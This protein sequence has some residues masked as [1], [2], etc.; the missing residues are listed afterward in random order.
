MRAGAYIYGNL[1]TAYI[2]SREVSCVIEF[3]CIQLCMDLN[4][5]LNPL[6]PLDSFRSKHQKEEMRGV[7]FPQ[8]VSNKFGLYAFT[9]ADRKFNCSDSIR[10][11]FSTSVTV[12]AVV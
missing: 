2:R 12:I 9:E 7:L 8:R 4:K 6:G 11:G 5:G 10:R 3:S 1:D